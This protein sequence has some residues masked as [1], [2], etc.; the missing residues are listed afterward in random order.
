MEKIQY[1]ASFYLR[2]IHGQT[3][4]NNKRTFHCTELQLGYNIGSQTD[5][6]RFHVRISF[7]WRWLSNTEQLLAELVL[8]LACDHVTPAALL[9]VG[10]RGASEMCTGATAPTV[11]CPAVTL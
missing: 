8:Q 1:S 5:V 11:D 7:H 4:L 9:S 2:Y 6:S 10:P 3:E